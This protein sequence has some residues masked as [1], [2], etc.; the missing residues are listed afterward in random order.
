[1]V[2]W[3]VCKV[4]GVDPKRKS[5]DIPNLMYTVARARYPLGSHPGITAP[6]GGPTSGITGPQPGPTRGIT[7][8]LGTVTH[9]N[10][11][12]Q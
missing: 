1:M 5:C 12:S 3:G 7:Y 10:A 9:S 2:K 8:H 6:H 11:H 4:K